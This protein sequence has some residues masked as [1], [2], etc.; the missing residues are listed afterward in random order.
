MALYFLYLSQIF[1]IAK[2]QKEDSTNILRN[3]IELKGR[4]YNTTIRL[5][6][7]GDKV[8]QASKSNGESQVWQR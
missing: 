7:L 1:F 2:C 5:V 8:S 3:Q 6:M 4:I